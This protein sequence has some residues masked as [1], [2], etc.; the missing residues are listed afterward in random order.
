MISN[1]IYTIDSAKKSIERFCVYQER[2]H[3]EVMQKLRSMRLNTVEIDNVMVHLIEEGYLN[4]ERFACAYVWGKF[5]QK[6]WGKIRL[7]SALKSKNISAFLID[8]SMAQIDE[9]TY[10]KTLLELATKKT[11]SL[12]ALSKT[13]QLTKTSNYLLYRGWEPELVYPLVKKLIL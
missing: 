7:R 3:L 8:K 5:N 4:E 13:V 12:K 11:E 2:C 10:E 9:D 6:K 1:K